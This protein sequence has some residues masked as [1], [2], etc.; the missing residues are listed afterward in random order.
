MYK[1]LVV[2]M[3]VV[4]LEDILAVHMLEV[5]VA[6]HDPDPQHDPVAAAA[7]H[8]AAAQVGSAQFRMCTQAECDTAIAV[9][10]KHH[11]HGVVAAVVPAAG[12]LIAAKPA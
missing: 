5:V 11:T 7:A 4:M 8:L 2:L 6:Q 1:Y 10:A 12:R 9:A 3:V